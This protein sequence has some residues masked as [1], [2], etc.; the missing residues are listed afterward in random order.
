MNND[1]KIEIQTGAVSYC[2]IGTL[3]PK[4]GGEYTYFLEAF[5]PTHPFGGPILAFLFAWVVVFLLKPSSLAILSLSFAKY[6]TTPIL[7]AVDYCDDDPDRS[8]AITRLTA[9]LCIGNSLVNLSDY[10]MTLFQIKARN[11]TSCFSK[12]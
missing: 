6:L 12:V 4:S 3:I 8:Y 1:L 2:E 7:S 10:S 5:G 9:A 11:I